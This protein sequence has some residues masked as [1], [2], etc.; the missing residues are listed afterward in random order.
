VRKRIPAGNGKILKTE[1]EVNNMELKTM[2][3]MKTMSETELLIHAKA[4][5]DDEIIGMCSSIARRKDF[6]SVELD[7]LAQLIKKHDELCFFI[8]EQLKTKS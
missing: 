6:K 1:S 8:D 7:K 2:T 3:V 4:S 5:I